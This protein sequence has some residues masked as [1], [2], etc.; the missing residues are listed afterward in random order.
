MIVADKMKDHINTMNNVKIKLIKQNIWSADKISD[1][2]K[3]HK[4]IDH[5]DISESKD[6]LYIHMKP[7]HESKMNCI[8][9][10]SYNSI[11]NSTKKIMNP[12]SNSIKSILDSDELGCIKELGINK[13]MNMMYNLYNVQNMLVMDI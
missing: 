10:G 8:D 9:L 3:T 12:R 2:L 6:R 11:S 1:T 4:D 5:I 7:S 13:A